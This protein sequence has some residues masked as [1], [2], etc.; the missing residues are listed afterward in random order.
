MP[1]AREDNVLA[2]LGRMITGK[3]KRRADRD[4]SSFY[5]VGESLLS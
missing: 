3:L 1:D 5:E 2:L 4:S